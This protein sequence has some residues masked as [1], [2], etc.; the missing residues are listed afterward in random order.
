M[1]IFDVDGVLTDGRLYYADDG[2]EYKAFHVQ[3]GSAIKMLRSNGVEVAIISGRESPSVTRRAAE[4][5]IPHVYQAAADKVSALKALSQATQ[6]EPAAMAHVGDDLPD[7]GLFAAVGLAIGVP[8]GHSVARA[9][10]GYVTRIAGGHGAASEVCQLILTA[11][12]KWPYH[13]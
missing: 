8:N 12:G 9:A 13:P 10:A 7:L 6:I 3:D 4:L 1:V 5:G 11:Q 2:G